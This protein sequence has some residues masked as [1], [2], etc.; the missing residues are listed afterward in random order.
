MEP[1]ARDFVGA[2]V[3]VLVLLGAVVLLVMAGMP[4]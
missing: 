4:G 2:V 3:L 1:K